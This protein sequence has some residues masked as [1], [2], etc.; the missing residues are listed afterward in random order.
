[1]YKLP[2]FTEQDPETIVAFMKE[3]PFATV[4]GCNEKNIAATQIPLLVHYQKNEIKLRGHFMRHTDHCEAFLKNPEAM[5]MF[6]GAQCYVSASWYDE[7]GH[8]STWNYMTV[9]A[10]GKMVFYNDE[11]TIGLLKELTHFYEDSQEHP[12][13]LE[14]MTDDYVQ[15]SV[16]AILGF[17]VV[18]ENVQ[19]TF[20][21]SQNRNDESYKKIVT[22]LEATNKIQEQSIANEM[23][24]RR[25]HLFD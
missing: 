19:A 5:F 23:K 3:Y 13:L 18:L 2:H 17:E 4:I 8:G 15:H 25:P 1:M 9:Q 10:R 21:L 20:K 7:R 16:K 24:K 6:H 11:Q 22:A 12:E 14:N